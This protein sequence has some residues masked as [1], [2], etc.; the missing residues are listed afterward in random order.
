MNAL[1]VVPSRA[2]AR[3]RRSRRARVVA[4][5]NSARLPRRLS[6]NIGEVQHPTRHCTMNARL[7]AGSRTAA[8]ML[9]AAVRRRPAG[10]LTRALRAAAAERIT[11]RKNA[12]LILGLEENAH[13]PN[14][15]AALRLAKRTHPDVLAREAREAEAARAADVQAKTSHFD[16]GV[17]EEDFPRG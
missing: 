2:R 7:C 15:D 5:M 8:T 13:A 10:L 1:T 9:V 12:F 17:I 3:A 16:V 11:Q 4:G 14:Q 6:E